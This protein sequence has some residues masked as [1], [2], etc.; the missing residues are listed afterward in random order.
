MQT[1]NHHERLANAAFGAFARS[2][3]SFITGSLSQRSS[4]SR[5]A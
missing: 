3:R 4:I 2:M 5:I 1:S